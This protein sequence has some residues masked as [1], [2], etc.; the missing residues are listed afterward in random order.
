MSR[1]S[2]DRET[3]TDGAQ[4]LSYG[5]VSWASQVGQSLVACGEVPKDADHIELK[6]VEYSAAEE[7]VVR[8][9]SIPQDE[10]LVAPALQVSSTIFNA[11]PQD[12]T[13]P[14][15]DDVCLY[16]FD[17]VACCSGLHEASSAPLEA[18]EVTTIS[19]ELPG[20]AINIISPPDSAFFVSTND[21]MEL[22]FPGDKEL[23][24]RV[25]DFAIGT[26]FFDAP[27]N[28][29]SSGL[30]SSWTY[31][32]ENF[33][34]DPHKNQYVSLERSYHELAYDYY[35][36]AQAQLVMN[37]GSRH[38]IGELQGRISGS[39]LF[40]GLHAETKTC[41]WC[42]STDSM[43]GIHDD[44]TGTSFAPANDG[45]DESSQ[46]VVVDPTDT[47]VNTSSMAPSMIGNATS[48]P[49]E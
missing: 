6:T 29:V 37:D 39:Q 11:T 14:N 8:S 40:P 22:G 5:P 36:K 43:C 31:P 2:S 48:A 15:I 10:I 47:L 32:V 23:D 1:Y 38:D 33:Q 25:T 20:T 21:L 26:S 28:P 7:P 42:N 46:V 27:Y 19:L 24:L 34:V 18:E 45:R 49:T 12:A 17:G 4:F 41:F 16:P 44:M 3:V 13:Q 35:W 30:A 9:V